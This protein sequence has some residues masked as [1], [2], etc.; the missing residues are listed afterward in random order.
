MTQYPRE[1]TDPCYPVED[2]PD[3]YSKF[4]LPGIRRVLPST[5]SGER[6]E[7]TGKIGRAYGFSVENAYV[8]HPG[9]GR[10]V[11]V[12]AA[13]Y[14]NADGVLNDDLYEYGAVADPFF[15]DLGELVARRW[16]Q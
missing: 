9:T 1:S 15:A 2:Y 5:T 6:I 4:L 7:I 8:R 16:L 10:A 3:A 12:T 11:F 14:T 13:I